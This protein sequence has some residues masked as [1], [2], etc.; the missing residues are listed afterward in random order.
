VIAFVFPGQGS[1]KVGMGRALAESFPECRAVFDEADAALGESL[2]GLCF[3]GPKIG[4]CSPRTRSRP[5]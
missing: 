1:Q 2:S 3:E 5:S 4:S